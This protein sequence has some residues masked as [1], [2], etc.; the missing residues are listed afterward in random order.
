MQLTI[1]ITLLTTF[2]HL[3]E[4]DTLFFFFHYHIYIY[5]YKS[6]IKVKS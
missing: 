6:K 4:M 1:C 3:E 2:S 5:K